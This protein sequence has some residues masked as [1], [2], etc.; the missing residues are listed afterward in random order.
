M[1][2]DL[3]CLILILY[4]LFLSS[5]APAQ[6]QKIYLHP[7]AA[8]TDKQSKFI[9]SIRFI[10]LEVQ[11]DVELARF[12]A[13]EVT[14]NYF[15]IKDW[16][17]KAIL[18]YAKDGRFVKKVSFKRIGEGIY[19]AYD[20]R[21][22]Q[23]VFFGNNKN[24]ALT[25]K[26]R[27][28][29]KLDWNNPR[30]RK[31][32]KKYI[33]DLGDTSFAIKKSIPRQNDILHARYFYDDLYSMGEINTSE[34]Y[35]D[36]LD[37]EFKI[38][39]NDQLVKGYFPYNRINEAKFLYKEENVSVVSTDTPYIHFI[40][41]PYCDTVYKMVRDSLLPGY[42][43]VLPLENSLPA[44]FF[45]RPL[46][47]K[48]DRDNFDRNNGMMLHQVYAFYDAPRFIYFLMGYLNNYEYY[49][50]QKQT[51]TTYK[52]KNIKPDSTQYNLSLLDDYGITRKG[53]RFYKTQK[54][55]EILSFFEKN[56]NV[57]VPK[58]L[59]S[60]IKSNPPATAPIIIEY[61]LKN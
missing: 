38:Y 27:I 22:N 23:I 5:V 15:I 36:S 20:E 33:I 11:G 42:Q 7:K 4:S 29:I 37:Y 41:R 47:N 12:S 10:P 6:L 58:E 40:T 26:D 2:N 59:E 17:N 54:V 32:Y 34:L 50:Y 49:I 9:D 45:T 51:N 53:D 16:I 44:S 61:K 19:P 52:V 46:K 3:R 39:K 25:P 1:T 57:P 30:N 24:Y 21:T 28:K 31:Y 43:I 18:V 8:G 13:V 55:G 35:K 60:F 14:N 48:T 56:K